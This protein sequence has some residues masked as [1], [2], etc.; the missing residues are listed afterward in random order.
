MKNHKKRAN[1]EGSIY[2]N[3]KKRLYI[4]QVVMGYDENGKLK[5]KSVSGDNKTEVRQ[6]MKQIE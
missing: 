1:G 3:E 2:Y 6:R 4:G 5:R